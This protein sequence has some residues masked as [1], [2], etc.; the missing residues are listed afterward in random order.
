[1]SARKSRSKRW[2]TNLETPP[3]SEAGR[4]TQ[5]TLLRSKISPSNSTYLSCNKYF[6]IEIAPNYSHRRLMLS[7]QASATNVIAATQASTKQPPDYNL[8]LNQR[9]DWL[10]RRC[11][12]KT[13]PPQIKLCQRSKQPQWAHSWC[14][15]REVNL[16]HAILEGQD[17]SQSVDKHL[18]NNMN[19]TAS[20]VWVV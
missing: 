7:G 10:A 15:M 9:W 11:S 8:K 2:S 17:H 5:S 12:Q 4:W 18:S 6:M 13:S 19:Q 20:W 14:N 3:S 1:M 16:S